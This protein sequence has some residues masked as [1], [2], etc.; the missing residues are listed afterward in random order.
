ME[1][2]ISIDYAL[3]MAKQMKDCLPYDCKLKLAINRKEDFEKKLGISAP[4]AVVVN[5]GSID[6]EFYIIANF[7]FTNDEK[8]NY[9]VMGHLI[10]FVNQYSNGI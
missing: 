2:K 1:K 5:Y 8:K 7:Q 10:T 3:T 4:D 6:D 9:D